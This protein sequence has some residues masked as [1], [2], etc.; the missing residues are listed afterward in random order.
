MKTTA[1]ADTWF[2]VFRAWHTQ[3]TG[4]LSFLRWETVI[5]LTSCSTPWG[6][7]PVVCWL[8]NHAIGDIKACV[9]DLY[10]CILSLPPR[11][12]G[13]H[14]HF[15]NPLI[16]WRRLIYSSWEKSHECKMQPPVHLPLYN[17]NKVILIFV[18]RYSL[19]IIWLN[20][21]N[22]QNNDYKVGFSQKNVH[23]FNYF[24][25]RIHD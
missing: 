14:F 3:L 23:I 12:A 20:F 5:S 10:R 18:S 1:P 4:F 21:W 22:P 24:L 8:W 13:T 25:V 19:N 6:N 7:R 2:S 9:C 16:W 15:I 11:A 17:D